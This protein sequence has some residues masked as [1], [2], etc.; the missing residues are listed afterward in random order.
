[1]IYLSLI[2]IRSNCKIHSLSF[3][4]KNDHGLFYMLYVA[5]LWLQVALDNTKLITYF[6]SDSASPSAK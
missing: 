2:C 5:W 4:V 3:L 6:Y 1:M